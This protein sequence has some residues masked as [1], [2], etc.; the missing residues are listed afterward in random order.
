[1]RCRAGGALVEV[2]EVP[3]QLWVESA[4]GDHEKALGELLSLPATAEVF[5]MLV[6]EAAAVALSAG[7]PLAKDHRQRVDQTAMRMDISSSMAEDL[8]AGWKIELDAFTGYVIELGLA[9]GIPTPATRAVH[10]IL[11]ALDN[12]T[13]AR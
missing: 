2:A 8:A 10:G 5:T 3:L 11:V 7:A 6:D 12:A 9:H 13:A 1:M 4:H